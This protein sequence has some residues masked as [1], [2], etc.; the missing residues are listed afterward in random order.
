[1]AADKLRSFAFHA[2]DVKATA[3]LNA[4]KRERTG[5]TLFRRATLV[6]GLPTL[7]AETAARLHLQSALSSQA[8]PEFTIAAPGGQATDFKALGVETIPLTGTRTVKFRQVHTT[9]PVYGSLVTV[10]L[11]ENNEL[12]A[13]SSSLGEPTDVD[14]VATIA[15]AQALAK[16]R[17]LSGAPQFKAV[18]QLWY[19]PDPR[20]DRW[21]LI[22]LIEDVPNRA[23]RPGAETGSSGGEEPGHL[24]SD[25]PPLYVDYMIDAHT[26]DLL[27]EL[28]RTMNMAERARV[29]SVDEN[30]VTREL[31]CVRDENGRLVLRDDELNIHTYDLAYGDLL[32]ESLPGAYVTNP[33]EWEPAAVSA[34]ANAI[35]VGGFLR[36]VLLRNGIDNKGG[37]LVSTIRCTHLL[38][39]PNEHEW[40]NA[41]WL[42]GNVLQMI[43]GQKR[44]EGR[45]RS[46]AAALDVVAHEMFHGVTNQTARLEYQGES[47]ALNESYSDIFAVLVSNLGKPDQSAWNWEIGEDLQ[48]NDAGPG[49]PVR[50]LENPGKYGQPAH[51][52]E[53]QDWPLTRDKGGVHHN[54]G[55]HNRAAYN[56]MTAKDAAGRH[57]FDIRSLA[58]MFYLALTQY[59]SRTSRFNHSRQA[60]ELSAYT[61]FRSDPVELRERKIEAIRNGFG[62]V[63]I[64]PLA[65]EESRAPEAGTPAPETHGVL[66]TPLRRVDPRLLAARP[67]AGLR[68]RR[69]PPR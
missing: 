2:Q 38:Y 40:H 12:L 30:G 6:R 51:M 20:T 19:Y 3:A 25:F 69:R 23:A 55:I 15:P 36:D 39:S 66:A 7:D 56:V 60:V 57:L 59:L 16:A 5:F 22:Y 68:V 63:G 27:A 54:S 10:E 47:G 49:V 1:M 26:G 37:R 31:W 24:E 9:I 50:D 48:R 13:I 41:A 52:T 45:L 61:L 43:Y 14:P 62:A 4:L 65:P 46:Y 35:V 32:T 58:A 44:V 21:H 18:P 34:H 8:L 11:D 67:R 53:Y 29:Q 33:P 28:P 17:E 64:G 42:G